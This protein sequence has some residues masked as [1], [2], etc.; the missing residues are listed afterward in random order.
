[1]S[2]GYSTD[3]KKAWFY[4]PVGDDWGSLP[5]MNYQHGVDG[6]ANVI[7]DK[8][9]VMGGGAGLTLPMNS[10]QAEVFD[11]EKWET[12]E[13]MP[14]PVL[15]HIS[16]VHDNKI[17]VLGVIVVLIPIKEGMQRI[18]FRNMIPQQIPGDECKVCPLVAQQ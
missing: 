4:N 10:V 9:Y 11:G 12:I 15:H 18:L 17:L 5:E 1:M 6:T 7:D 8:I 16:V 2:D 14:I 13:D 3:V